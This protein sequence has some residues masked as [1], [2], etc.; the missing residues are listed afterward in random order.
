M[1]SSSRCGVGCAVSALICTLI[2][3]CRP[4]ECVELMID[5]YGVQRTGTTRQRQCGARGSQQGRGLLFGLCGGLKRGPWG[6]V[7]GN[8]SC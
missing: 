4:C 3:H 6:S 1:A 5:V 2:L 7:G 8:T